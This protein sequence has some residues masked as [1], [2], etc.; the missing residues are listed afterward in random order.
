MIKQGHIGLNLVKLFRDCGVNRVV[1]SVAQLLL[2]GGKQLGEGNR[3]DGS[4]QR[5][6]GGYLNGIGLNAHLQ[7]GKI[8]GGMDFLLIVGE[9]AHAE[10]HITGQV[11]GGV[12]IQLLGHNITEFSGEDLV[13]NFVALEQER[14]IHGREG[15][16]IVAPAGHGNFGHFK[17]A[18]GQ[19]VHNIVGAAGQLVAGINLNHNFPAGELLHLVHKG[20]EQHAGR[21]DA[22]V[23]LGQAAGYPDDLGGRIGIVGDTVNIFLKA[24]GSLGGG[25]FCGR[26]RSSRGGCGSG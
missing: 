1:L 15:G 25:C 6:K 17:R 8:G 5:A 14:D 18:G 19:A 10:I 21:G 13:R 4:A 24:D 22:I 9:G 20:F 16:G 11:H 7:A 23:G 2:Q 3:H 26:G 12:V